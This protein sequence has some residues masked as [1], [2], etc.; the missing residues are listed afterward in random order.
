M[1]DDRKIV[2]LIEEML[3]FIFVLFYG[4]IE[5][6]KEKGVYFM[7]NNKLLLVDGMVFLFWVFFV[8]V[9]YCNFMINESGVLMNGVNGFLK[10]LII[11]VEIFQLIYVVCCWDMGS[12]MY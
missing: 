2:F 3:F 5:G 12:K 8:M 9:V 7:N 10:Y 4:K 6:M 1:I 11:V